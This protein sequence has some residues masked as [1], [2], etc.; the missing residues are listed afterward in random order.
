MMIY[1]KLK[2][3]LRHPIFQNRYFLLSI[4]TIL[5]LV[6]MLKYHRSDN[7]F[8]IFR[9]V[10]WHTWQQTSLY[11]A[12]PAEY[13]D[14]NHYGPL[15]SLIIAPFALLPH[16][17]G[18]LFWLLCLTLWLYAAI[19]RSTLAHRQQVFIYWFC[20]FALLT[21]LFMQQFN[22]AIA[23]MVLSSFF[24]VE[25]EQEPWAAFF[26]VLGTLVKLYGMVGLAFF[27][28][29][30]HKGRF[31][32]WLLLWSVVLFCLPMLIS[33]PHYVVAQYHE[34]WVC[35]AEKNTENL[36]ALMQ[37]ISLLG[38]VRRTTGCENYSDLWLIVP[39]MVL[40][41]LPYL[42]FSQYKH[43]A[44]REAILASV[45]MF[46]ILFS[47]GS[48][49]SGYI[50]ALLGAAIWYVS[51]PFERGKW[52]VW[53][54]VFVFILSGMGN[55]DLIPKAIR[56]TIIQPYALRALPISLLWFCLCYELYTKDYAPLNE[57]SHE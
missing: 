56:T 18:L 29:S 21:A 39:G 7:N 55:S 9:G 1:D 5:A 15:F 50:I 42:R 52:A 40:F 4:W 27:L 11:A 32:L 24:L 22:I 57:N 45:L 17:V 14:V 54:M 16:W 43:L 47:T 8:L 34:W 2:A 30:R 6:G 25:K 23:A 33:S 38:M 13:F 35:L 12:Y 44:F 48:E 49:S 3:F 36:H 20:G 26:I 46:I 51:A 41:A 10:F 28:F 37:N 19:Y 53:L 31:V